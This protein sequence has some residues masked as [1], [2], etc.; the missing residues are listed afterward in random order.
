MGR[1]KGVSGKSRPDWQDA[2]KAWAREQPGRETPFSQGTISLQ[3]FQ[4]GN[5]P[6]GAA[7]RGSR[8]R[9]QV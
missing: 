6:H 7:A 3:G 1:Q 8:W 4:Y 2:G 9:G 5:Q